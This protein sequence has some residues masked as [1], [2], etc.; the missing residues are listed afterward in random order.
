VSVD[1]RH[2][3]GDMGGQGGGVGI[4]VLG[5]NHPGT[6]VTSALIDRRRNHLYSQHIPIARHDNHEVAL[7]F[8]DAL[9]A[10]VSNMTSEA[11]TPEVTVLLLGD[12]EIGK[13]T[14]LS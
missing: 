3:C 11:F 8:H 1:F 12:A 6:D 2:G 4:Y 14:F 13:S 9:V 5:I 7:R 10:S